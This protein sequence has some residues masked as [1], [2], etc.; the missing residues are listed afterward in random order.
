MI[1]FV[2]TEKEVQYFDDRFRISRYNKR[3]QQTSQE[4]FYFLFKLCKYDDSYFTDYN[5]VTIEFD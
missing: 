1:L 5:L 4:T 2:A 3:D